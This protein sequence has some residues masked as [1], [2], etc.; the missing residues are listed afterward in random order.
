MSWQQETA[1]HGKPH[2]MHFYLTWS[3]KTE[4]K[5]CNFGFFFCCVLATIFLDCFILLICSW[6][7]N[8]LVIIGHGVKAT[9][10]YRGRYIINNNE[11]HWKLPLSILLRVSLFT[12]SHS[13]IPGLLGCSLE[14]ISQDQFQNARWGFQTFSRKF[15]TFSKWKEKRQSGPIMTPSRSS[16]IYIVCES[17]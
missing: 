13:F 12:N 2:I 1:L 3:T 16:Y 11:F 4:C 10:N 15:L 5:R 7:K 14:A 9:M 17:W 8:M 6:H